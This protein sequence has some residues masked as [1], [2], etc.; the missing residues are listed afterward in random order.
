MSFVTN[1]SPNPVWQLVDQ[2]G[3]I[4]ASMNNNGATPQTVGAAGTAY[5]VSG[6]VKKVKVLISSAQLLALRATPILNLIPA[7]G[8][9]S[10]N[11]VLQVSFRYLFGTVAYTLNAGT[12]KLFYGPVASAK[13]LTAS[14]ATGLVDQVANRTT[15]GQAILGQANLTDAQALNVDIELGNDGAA[16]LSLGDGTLEVIIF[17]K[18]V[19]VP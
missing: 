15:L 5:G 4:L 2:S 12:I 17:Y 9:S 13:A 8:A 6:L 16:E 1:I 7:A 18:I 19:T 3:N 11:Q 14:V 10:F